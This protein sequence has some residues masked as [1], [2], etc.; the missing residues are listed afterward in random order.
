MAE[1]MYVCFY[2]GCILRIWCVVGS[3]EN[4]IGI[5]V[6]VYWLTDWESFLPDSGLYE[7][8]M[9]NPYPALHMRELRSVDKPRHIYLQSR[10]VPTHGPVADSR[11]EV[12]KCV[13][14]LFSLIIYHSLC[15]QL[16]WKC[17]Y[18]V[19]FSL[20]NYFGNLFTFFPFKNYKILT[21]QLC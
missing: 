17:S 9:S 12:F 14:C 1:I 7:S 18:I 13:F 11:E 15:S 20:I 5:I 10:E 3:L 6:A 4:R 2:Q 8:R 16:K 19:D 21:C